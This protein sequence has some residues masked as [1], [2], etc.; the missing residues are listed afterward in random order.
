MEEQPVCRSTRGEGCQRL[1]YAF[2]R[3]RARC[4]HSCKGF[5]RGNVTAIFVSLTVLDVLG[6]TIAKD[7]SD[8]LC[9]PKM[10]TPLQFCFRQNLSCL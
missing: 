2:A 6:H 8:N 5:Q 4:E 10:A 7:F 3:D 9:W 1:W